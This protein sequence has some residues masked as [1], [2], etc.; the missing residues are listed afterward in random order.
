[1]VE[2]PGAA[3][4]ITRL[5]AAGCIF[6]E[7]EAEILLTSSESDAELERFVSRRVAGT[8]LEYIV[9]WAEF[10]GLRI[11]VDEGVFVP[12]RRTEFLVDLCVDGI[13]PAS[14]VLDL[15][16]GAGAL[17]AA[18]VAE[19]PDADVYAADI[20][21]IAVRCARGNL[22]A[23]R[24]LEGDLFAA[25]PVSLRDR[26]EVIVVNA[27]YVPTTEIA[28]MPLEARNFEALVALDGGDDGLHV[29]RRVAAEARDWLVP[30]GVLVIETSEHHAER[31]R[32]LFA[33]RGFDAQV[34]RDEDRDATAVTARAPH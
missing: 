31:T 22:S 26:V 10:R 9:G 12:R 18:I 11:G 5:R 32:A 6:A 27:P 29:H 8:P 21:P 20:D 24:V 4:V 33:D 34:R 15:C 17:A 23:D 14:V 30:G 1:M 2:S 16:C 7:E 13:G 25:L 3:G 19:V 28:F